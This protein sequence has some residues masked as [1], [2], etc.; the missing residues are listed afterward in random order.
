MVNKHQVESDIEIQPSVA[1]ST[2]D[3]E[4]KK[5]AIE[6]NKFQLIIIL[7]ALFL[8]IASTA[9]DQ[10]IIITLLI[11]IASRFNELSK[12][13]VFSIAY[14]SA[15]FIIEKQIVRLCFK[16]SPKS[17]I[18]C[19]LLVFLIGLIIAGLSVNLTML[20]VARVIMGFG[21]GGL[22]ISCILII[23]E[24]VPKDKFETYTKMAIG[25]FTLVS[26]LGSF[27]N[28]IFL[29]DLT[30]RWCFYIII[31]PISVAF[32]I[33]VFLLPNE[34]KIDSDIMIS[35]F[36]YLGTVTLFSFI[37]L[38][39]LSLNWANQVYPWDSIAVILALVLSILLLFGFVFTQLKLSKDPILKCP[40]L[41]QNGILCCAI[42][43]FNGAVF[44]VS[45]IY[46]LYYYQVL[47]STSSKD[48]VVGVVP[49]IAGIIVAFFIIGPITTKTNVHRPI[50]TF[51]TLVGVLGA[52]LLSYFMS[53][54]VTKVK[55]FCSLALVGLSIGGNLKMSNV[56]SQVGLNEIESQAVGSMI[57][58]FFHFGGIIGVIISGAIYQNVLL[59][60]LSKYSSEIDISALINNTS[61]ISTLSPELENVIRSYHTDAFK[62][63]LYTFIIFFSIGAILSLFLKRVG[64]VNKD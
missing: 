46:F 56:I 64:P 40:F 47:Q 32:I 18:L 23:R 35:E 48:S 15:A 33:L 63:V 7:F 30:W 44:F 2:T 55:L 61:Y 27:L 14:L 39:A 37:V 36:D 4:I 43:F 34:F 31:P 54:E 22:L 51:S 11:P 10:T 60:L 50:L 24:I 6:L 13:S 53:L 26:I 58:F 29:K 38:L 12:L 57:R 49:M 21:A 20:I 8:I 52:I 9:F 1:G 42:I 62:A 19:S 41:A 17:T 45:I 28:D 16:Y 59:R 3:L 5:P 25:I